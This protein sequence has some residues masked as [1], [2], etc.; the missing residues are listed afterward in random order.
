[1]D[2]KC[3]LKTQAAQ[4]AVVIRTLTSVEKLPEVLG[5]AFLLLEQH[6]H[7]AAV[8][9]AGPPFV[10]Y[11]NLDMQNMDVEIGFPSAVPVAGNENVASISVPAGDYATH[12]FVGNYQDM[13]PAYSALN[14]FI[15]EKGRE[16]TGVAYEYYLTD[17]DVQPPQTL[18]SLPL[19]PV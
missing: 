1:M 17:P 14:A 10:A 15:R 18:I 12:L 2:Y 13:E 8:P 11:Y 3:E 4:P 9:P 19:K 5:T 6:L 16:P 7:L